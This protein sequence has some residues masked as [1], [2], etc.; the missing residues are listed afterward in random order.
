MTRYDAYLFV[1]I[2]AAIIW[3]GSGF[4]LTV[5]AYRTERANDEQRIRN[6][7][8][9]SNALGTRLFIPS[10]LTVVAFGIL[11]VVDGPWT[12]NYLWIVLGLVGYAATSVS[13]AFVIKP[14][15]ERIEEMIKREGSISPAAM[16]EIRRLLWF[17]RIDLVTLFLVIFDMAVKPSGDDTAILVGMAL[18]FLAGGAFVASRIRGVEEA[19]EPQVATG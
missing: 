9:D 12:F 15:S 1:H 5:L 11:M 2:A 16:T 10:S 3:V 8:D 6:L 18:V 14:W 19:P 7:L 13:G 17:G 4:L